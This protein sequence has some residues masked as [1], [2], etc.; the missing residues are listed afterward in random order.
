LVLATAPM[1]DLF[2]AAPTGFALGDA[3]PDDVELVFELTG[4]GGGIW[5]LAHRNKRT[6]VARRAKPRPDCWV[7]CSV[8]DFRQMITGELSM[9]R[10]FLDGRVRARG[11]VG[12]VINVLQA[13]RR[14]G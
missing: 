9:R 6:H 11:D 2:A 7:S 3:L 10:A 8:E 12:L 1:D 5:T 14:E 4:D 13:I